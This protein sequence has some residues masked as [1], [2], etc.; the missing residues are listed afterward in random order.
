MSVSSWLD[1]IMSVVLTVDMSMRLARPSADRRR[2]SELSYAV[3]TPVTPVHAGHTAGRRGHRSAA[4]RSIDRHAVHDRHHAGTLLRSAVEQ[5]KA[6]HRLGSGAAI[7][8]LEVTEHLTAQ[9]DAENE[10]QHRDKQ[11]QSVV[12]DAERRTCRCVRTWLL[13]ENEVTEEGPTCARARS[14]LMTTRP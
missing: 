3:T 5:L 10:D 13:P 14:A 4:R 1:R 6:A 9:Y 11:D 12:P 8:L 2:R 7:G